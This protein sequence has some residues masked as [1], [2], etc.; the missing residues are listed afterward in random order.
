MRIFVCLRWTGAQSS[1]V[2]YEID[3]LHQHWGRMLDVLSINPEAYGYQ[4][5]IVLAK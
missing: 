4:T 5:A 2:F 1:Q 3:Y